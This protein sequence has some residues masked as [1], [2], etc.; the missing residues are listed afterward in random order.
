MRRQITAAIVL[1]GL[2]SQ[3][4]YADKEAVI[5]AAAAH[6]EAQWPTALNIWEWAEPGYQEEKSSNA[7]AEIAEQAGFTVTRD[8]ADIPTAFVAEYGGGKPV[9]ALLGE[10]DALPALSQDAVPYRTTRDG[11]NGYGQACGHHLFGVASLSAAIAIAEQI[12]AGNIEGT[13]RFYLCP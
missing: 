3:P 8:V 13:V 10:V 12:E 7:L 6:A 5:Q 11:G 4:V 1:M 2:A 9:V